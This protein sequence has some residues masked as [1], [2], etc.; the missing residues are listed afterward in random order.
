[1][2][3]LTPMLRVGHRNLVDPAVAEIVL[4]QYA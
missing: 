4:P 3:P 1:V 2:S